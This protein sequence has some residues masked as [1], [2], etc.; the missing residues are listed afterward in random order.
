ML[1]NPE[2][3]C[4]LSSVP[5]PL[6]HHVSKFMRQQSVT[7]RTSR[8]ILSRTKCNVVPNRKRQRMYISRRLCGL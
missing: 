6:L 2:V 7:V 8:R 1:N 3:T 5:A 4:P